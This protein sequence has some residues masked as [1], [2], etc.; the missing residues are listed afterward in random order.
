MSKKFDI[1]ELQEYLNED[2]LLK[3]INNELSND[4]VEKVEYLLHNN[5]MYSDL[6]D[7]L[8]MMDEPED[9]IFEKSELNKKIDTFSRNIKKQKERRYTKIRSIIITTV[10][11]LSLV[12]AYV[13]V[14]KFNNERKSTIE[15]EIYHGDLETDTLATLYLNNEIDTLALN[16]RYIEE[17]KNKQ[18]IE[19][20]PDDEYLKIV[21]IEIAVRSLQ[22]AI[23]DNFDQEQEINAEFNMVDEKP[24]FPGGEEALYNFISE[25]IK[26][27]SEEKQLGIQG[28]VIVQITINAQG[29]VTNEKVI[30]G[31]SPKLDSEAIRVIKLLPNWSPGKNKGKAVSVFY[32]IPVIFKLS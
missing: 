18:K 9:I 2:I 7:G 11:I 32:T 29:K 25:N 17:Y 13:L 3:Y 23:E 28:K 4:D 5:A 22:Y 15:I 27:P 12:S 14:V 26:Y 8:M 21:D 20:T 30:S 24:Q 6:F 19:V 31:V 16:N 10:V 1:S